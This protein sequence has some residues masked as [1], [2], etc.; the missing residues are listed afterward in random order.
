LF[1]DLLVLVFLGICDVALGHWFEIFLFSFNTC[2]HGY[3]FSSLD[4][5][6]CVP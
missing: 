1:W 4:C 3:K 5:L 2:T 6:C